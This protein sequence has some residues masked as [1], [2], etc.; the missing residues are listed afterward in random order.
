VQDDF[1]DDVGDI[2]GGWSIA[3]ETGPVDTLIPGSGT[4]GTAIPNPASRTISSHTALISDLNVIIDG[5]SHERPDDLDLLLVGLQGEKVVLMSDARGSFGVNAY[6]W[7]WNDEA[8]TP[9]PDGDT[10]N[11]CGTRSHRP[12][13]YGSGDFW[14]APAPAGP[15]ATSLSA[16]DLTDPN[17]EWRLFVNDDAAGGTGF[18]TN[19]F[20]LQ[21]TTMPRPDTTAPTVTSVSPASKATGVGLAANVSA[22]FSETMSAGSINTNTV[23]LFRAGATNAKGATVSY[24]EAAKKATLDPNVNL[25]RGAKYKAVVTTKVK[26]LAGNRLDQNLGVAG[27]QPRVWVFT[28]R[29]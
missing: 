7:E 1:E 16:F 22:T 23:K 6:G 28:V 9:M 29:R 27:N 2:E 18:F 26:D 25:R 21:I 14:P 11:V 20:Q 12:T 15:Y 19:R 8:A 24:D 10:T 3:I 4:S 5:I 13:N 17:G